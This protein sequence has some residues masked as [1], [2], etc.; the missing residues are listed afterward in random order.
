VRIV[1]LSALPGRLAIKW[2]ALAVLLPAAAGAQAM[3]KYRDANGQWVYT[4]RKPDESV[5]IETL[6]LGSS[7]SLSPRITIEQVRTTEAA[8]LRAIND[9]ACPVEFGL[10]IVN[11]ENVDVPGSG[12][13]SQ[14]VPARSFLDLVVL[15]AIG[16]AEPSIAFDW[17]YVI[18]EPN[19]KHAPARPYRVPF[20]VA[21]SFPVSQAYP[22]TYTHVDPASRHAIDIAMPEGTAIYAARGGVVI[23]VAHG[24]FK[25]GIA[26]ELADKANFVR[27]LH[28]DGTFAI[29]AHL[30][31]D[32]IRVRPGQNI[33]RGEFIATSGNTGF[34]SG[35]HL[36]FAVMRNVGLRIEA[37]PVM[38][39]GPGGSALMAREGQALTAY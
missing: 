17:G 39:E 32:S 12:T 29:Y 16:N 2:L 33:E 9:C 20:A 34:S 14:T 21:R 27:I 23:D 11:A 3:Y 1:K 38:F 10:R 31:W 36:H 18:G 25:S 28:A 37:L 30:R 7:E 13:Y 15:P 22:S 6:D 35:P 26:R 24:N 8:V 19:V 5:A 4:D